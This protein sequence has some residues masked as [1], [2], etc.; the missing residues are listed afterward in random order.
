MQEHDMPFSPSAQT[1]KNVGMTVKRHECGKQRLL[2]ANKVVKVE[3][4]LRFKR[5]QNNY[6]YICG[7][8]FNEIHVSNTKYKKIFLPEKIYIYST[9]QGIRIFVFFVVV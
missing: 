1:A 4:R 6:V 5:L 9:Q 7:G 2:Y 8:S 3:E